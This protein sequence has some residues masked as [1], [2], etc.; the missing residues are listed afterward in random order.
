MLNNIF[1]LLLFEWYLNSKSSH[2]R[3]VFQGGEVIDFEIIDFVY[4]I[5]SLL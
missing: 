4:D 2:R 1:L 5:L 3:S